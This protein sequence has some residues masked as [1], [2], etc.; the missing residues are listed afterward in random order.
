MA[1]L[2]QRLAGV[3]LTFPRA[4]TLVDDVL[5]EIAVPARR[6]QRPLL[7]AAAV[8]VAIVVATTA[9]PDARHAVARWLGFDSLRIE[10]VDRIPPDLVVEATTPPA[11]VI[12]ETLPG[13]STRGCT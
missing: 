5:A 1:E 10:V 8:L 6:W 11:D 13:G 7:V 12:V 9:V 2:E 3:A 4:D